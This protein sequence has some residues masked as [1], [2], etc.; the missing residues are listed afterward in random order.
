MIRMNILGINMHCLSYEEMYPIFDRWLSD[1]MSCSHSLA[2]I[3]AYICVCA[4]LDKKLRDIYNSNDLIG[5]DS[6]PFV[7]WA[8]TFYYKKSDHFNA[9]D[10]MLEISSKAKE[11]GYTFFLYGGY[12]GTP[13]KIE[14]FLNQR[15]DGIKI[16]GKY[17]PP[18]RVLTDE[19]EDAVCKLINDARPDFLW[20]G[21]GSPKQDIWIHDHL[22][23]IMGCIL[24]PSGATFDFFS[25]R[26]KQA[27]QWVRNFGF[28]WLFR[29]TQDFRRLWKRYTVY[30]IFFIIVFILQIIRIVTFTD[31][32]DLCLF[33]Q[34][35]TESE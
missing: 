5:I 15:F 6:Y 13:D 12:P 16:V 30:N 7:K 10:L 18:F 1:K 25:G 27:P 4:I 9:P 23:K 26:I 3:N 31:T 8:R 28:E 32:G 2:V 20:I 33:G 17:S 21:L 29:L 22:D 35:L 34:R 24:M 11:K 14:K 19:E